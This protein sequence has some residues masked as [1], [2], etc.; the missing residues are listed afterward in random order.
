[1]G[2][3]KALTVGLSQ[4]SEEDMCITNVEVAGEG[5][6]VTY[7]EGPDRAGWDH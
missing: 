4:G 6:N 2:W 1:M 5:K 3:S 7:V